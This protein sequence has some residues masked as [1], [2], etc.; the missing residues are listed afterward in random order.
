M[1][2]NV[3]TTL[4]RVLEETHQYAGTRT[5]VIFVLVEMA[6]PGTE[7]CATVCIVLSGLFV[8]CH[9]KAGIDRR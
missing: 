8:I 2:M 5:E 6:T 9:G 7:E 3:L 4:I 1:L